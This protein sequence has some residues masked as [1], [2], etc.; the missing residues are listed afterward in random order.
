MKFGPLVPR[1]SYSHRNIRRF[2][3]KMVKINYILLAL[4]HC[5]LTVHDHQMSL[6]YAK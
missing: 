6:K 2:L 1:T 5:K 4:Y 3:I